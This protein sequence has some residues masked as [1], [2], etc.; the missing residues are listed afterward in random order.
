MLNRRVV[1]SQKIV[2]GF[3]DR[4]V[5]LSS[6]VADPLLISYL[7]LTLTL[8]LIRTLTLPPTLILDRLAV[9]RLKQLR[10]DLRC[11]VNPLYAG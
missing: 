4:L 10:L 1:F 7:T 9:K 8:I 3:L 11:F 2:R 5:A 6:L